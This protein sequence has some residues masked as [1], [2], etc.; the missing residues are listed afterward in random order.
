VRSQKI[1]GG[2]ADSLV[3]PSYG[4]GMPVSAIEAMEYAMLVVVTDVGGILETVT[5]GC[6]GSQS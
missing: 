5:D 3:V 2:N 1:S 4:K 6:R